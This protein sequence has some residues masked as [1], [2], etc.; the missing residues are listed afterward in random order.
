MMLFE[1]VQLKSM[2]GMEIHLWGIAQ[3]FMFLRILTHHMIR[4]CQDP[5]IPI[6]SRLAKA[7][8]I[9]RARAFYQYWR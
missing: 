9:R 6:V 8:S 2:R 1:G 4:V 7:D 5:R 3:P